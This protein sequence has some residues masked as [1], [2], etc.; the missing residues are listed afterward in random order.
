VVRECKPLTLAELALAQLGPT[1]L[2]AISDTL[3]EEGLR[4]PSRWN[5]S[6]ARDFVAS[7]GFP[8]AFAASPETRRDPEEFISGPIDLPALHDF[9]EEVLEGIRVLAAGGSG[10]R[11]ADHQPAH[12]RRKDSRYCGSRG[13]AGTC[14]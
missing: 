7:I 3:A 4:P 9:Q 1:I 10:R 14:A 6:E 5:T 2:P 13:K 12:G 8:E 11:R